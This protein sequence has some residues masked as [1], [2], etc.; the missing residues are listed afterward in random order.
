MIGGEEFEDVRLQLVVLFKDNRV[1]AAFD[2]GGV[3]QRGRRRPPS[4]AVEACERLSEPPE[5]RARGLPVSCALVETSGTP[6][7]VERVTSSGAARVLNQWSK[8]W[9]VS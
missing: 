6:L 7:G 3:P 9:G 2:E 8:F 4:P 5:W 1:A